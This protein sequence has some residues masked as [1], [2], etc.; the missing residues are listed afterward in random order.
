MGRAYDFVV[1]G[2]LMM[3]SVVIHLI[4]VELFSPDKALF[5]IATD[6]T[7]AMNGSARAELW[8]EVLSIWMPLAVFAASMVYVMVREY[9]RQIQTATGQP[10][11][12]T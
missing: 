11:P 3:I 12:P 10:R 1:A 9:R 7:E 6:G 8:F 4:S 5:D 2:T